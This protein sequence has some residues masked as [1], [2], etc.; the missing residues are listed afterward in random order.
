MTDTGLAAFSNPLISASHRALAQPIWS[1]SEAL[2]R[3]S[4]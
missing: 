4:T 2:T 3:A 1:L